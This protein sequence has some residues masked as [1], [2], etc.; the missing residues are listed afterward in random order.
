MMRIVPLKIP[1]VARQEVSS[2]QNVHAKGTSPICKSAR[3]RYVP[4]LHLVKRFN[5][6]GGRT[7][8]YFDR[9]IGFLQHGMGVET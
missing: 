2:H 7:G 8:A 9:L 3:E 4:D 1:G 6:L 5:W